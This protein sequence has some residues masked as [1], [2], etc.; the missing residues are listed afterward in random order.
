M[1][2]TKRPIKFMTIIM[3][4][5]L[6]SCG[7]T[8]N[9][10][11]VPA[12]ME[13]IER[14]F[15]VNGSKEELYVKANNWMAETFI[16]SKDVIQFTDKESGTVTGKCILK[17]FQ[18]FNAY[19]SSWQSTGNLNAIIKI[20]VRDNASKITIDAEDFQE[21]H[22]SFNEGYRYTKDKAVEQINALL[23]SYEEYLKNNT[24]NEK[25]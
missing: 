8:S 16:S 12:I 9:V 4:L 7:I 1:M 11:Y 20:Q 22:S 23:D 6:A 15:Q 21:V 2:K 25:W 19:T 14:T 18:S 5:F 13:P 3:V 17:N 24:S 10:T